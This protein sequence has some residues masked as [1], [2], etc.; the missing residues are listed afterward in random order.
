MNEPPSD[1]DYFGVGHNS[2]YEWDGK[3]YFVSHAYVKDKNGD[4]KLFIRPLTF[5][6]D[7]W[8]VEED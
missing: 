8:I 5:D 3:C 2:V 4:A 7:G 6:K 1:E